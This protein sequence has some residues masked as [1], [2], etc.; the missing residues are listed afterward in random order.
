MGLLDS[1]GSTVDEYAGKANSLLDAATGAQKTGTATGKAEFVRDV[2][3][4]E[5]DEDEGIYTGPESADAP[6][7]PNAAETGIATEFIHFGKV[8][9]DSG[10]AFAHKALPDDAAKP[11]FEN[12]AIMFRDALE[13]EAIL[14]FGFIS[15]CKVAVQDTTKQRGGVEELAG[16]ASNL[17][18]GGNKTSKPD[19]KQLDTFLSKIKT[20]AGKINKDQILYKE[21]HE[22]GKQLHTIRG[23]YIAFC[24]SLNAFYLQPPKSEGIGAI[25]DAIGS[26]AANIPGVGKILG[27]V[28]RI[29]FK[30]LDLYLGAFLEIRKHHEK[31]IE[32]AVHQLTIEAI[33]GKYNDH[34]PIYP[35]W[36]KK[37]EVAETQSGNSGG[38][39]GSGNQISTDQVL[40]EI[41][42]SK[43]VK[44]AKE[45]AENVRDTIYDFAGAN[46]E[47]Q[48]TP[49]SAALAAAFAALKG[50]SGETTPDAVPS[51]ADCIILSMSGNGGDV[52]G[53]LS[54]IG[55][56]PEFMKTV[57]REIM[58]G[59]ISLL[60]DVFARLMANDA[61]AEINSAM[62]MQ[63][64]RKYLTDRISK[65][66]TKLIFGM[67]TGGSDFSVGVPFGGKTLSAQETLG[68]QLNER[69]G[70]YVE[71]VLQL[72]IGDLAGQLKASQEKAQK[73]KAQ[74]MEVYLG[75]LPWLAAMM[76][77]NT[78]FPIWN[79]VAEEVMGKVSPP[80][81]S[82][83]KAINEPINK[84]RDGV[85]RAQEY[86]RRAEE[87]EKQANEAK[88]K[89]SSVNVSS[90]IKQTKDELGGIK[91]EVGDVKEAPTTETEE[92]KQRA[93]EREAM[94]AEKDNLDKFYQDNDK[95]K[96]FPVTNR[97]EKGQAEKLKPE[98]EL[99]SVLPA[100]A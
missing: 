24:D 43:P 3:L 41:T 66:F 98:D 35:V 73:E 34:R 54:D 86:K 48:Q 1:V 51:A 25:G 45:T 100:G 30:F 74:T 10:K 81:K 64:G 36:F 31:T 21:T 2:A 80:L 79:L 97:V 53:T 42:D 83:L 82:A 90:D 29:A 28:H 71:P 76:F 52:K 60:E 94:E 15:S 62:L 9:A 17:L 78:F 96:E 18:G 19:P 8:H 46:G 44:T 20:E 67:L 99:P 61:A 50:G 91:K 89:L 87:T 65:A 5:D 70:K 63:G 37:P 88:D 13:R 12:H 85:D 72:C 4:S 6:F 27:V 23:D 95:D 16:M 33:K 32:T 38:G 77:R 14:L 92:G 57:I 68:H 93:A 22:C 40:K 75:R 84:A 49:G 11:P 39:I 69:L 56:V 55:G 59:N 58:E 7:P 26:A 47:P